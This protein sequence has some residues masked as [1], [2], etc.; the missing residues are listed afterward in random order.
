Y[1]LPDAD[2]SCREEHQQESNSGD[3]SRTVAARELAGAIMKCI[4]PR[5]DRQTD[6]IPTNVFRKLFNRRVTAARLFVKCLQGDVVQVAS[7]PFAKL[8]GLNLPS[9]ADPLPRQ[10]LLPL[11]RG[12]FLALP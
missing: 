12:R 6:Q 9:G 2:A 3:Q 4:L 1:P 7:D 11:L 5:V 8:C 10:H